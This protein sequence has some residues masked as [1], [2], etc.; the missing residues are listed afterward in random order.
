MNTYERTVFTRSIWTNGSKTPYQDLRASAVDHKDP[1]LAASQDK[2]KM[3]KR[4][5]RPEV[6]GTT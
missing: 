4:D 6:L 2:I 3:L 1:E 5:Q